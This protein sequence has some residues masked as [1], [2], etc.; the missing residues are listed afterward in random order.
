MSYIIVILFLSVVFLVCLK[1][2]YF[3]PISACRV[4]SDGVSVVSVKPSS[5]FFKQIAGS[6]DIG[7]VRLAPGIVA[8]FVDRPELPGKLSFSDLTFSSDL[9]IFK[10]S[11]GR[12]KSVDLSDRCLFDIIKK[13]KGV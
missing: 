9:F 4:S 3:H 8:Y 2:L 12:F 10:V 11:L 13:I 5:R 1:R 6:Y 7:S